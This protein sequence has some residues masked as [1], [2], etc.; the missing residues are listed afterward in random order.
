MDTSLRLPSTAPDSQVGQAQALALSRE[1]EEARAQPSAQTL[2]P[3]TKISL[4]DEGLAAAR[5]DAPAA[6]RTSATGPAAPVRAPE[7]IV[8]ADPV[9]AA[10]R[11]EG[12]TAAATVTG[13]EALRRYAENTANH[14]PAGQSGPSTVRVSA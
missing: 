2:A 3:S 6:T 1:R 13:Q 7:A 14:L 9:R 10:N 12:S 11:T 5:A 4:S 8:H